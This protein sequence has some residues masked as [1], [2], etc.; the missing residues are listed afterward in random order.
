M[1]ELLQDLWEILTTEQGNALGGVW[2]GEENG[3]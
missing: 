3:S 1:K 2:E